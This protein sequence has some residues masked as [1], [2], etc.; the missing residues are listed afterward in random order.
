MYSQEQSMLRVGDRSEELAAEQFAIS[1]WEWEGGP[2]GAGSARP[3]GFRGLAA[4]V[5]PVGRATSETV[6]ERGPSL[7]NVRRSRL[8]VDASGATG[9]PGEAPWRSSRPATALED[10]R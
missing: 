3:S 6:T 7:S 1:R 9:S 2:P 5:G 10:W 8:M 4:A